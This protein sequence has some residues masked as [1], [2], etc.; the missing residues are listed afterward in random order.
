MVGQMMREQHQFDLIMLD[1]FDFNYIPRHLMTQE[2]LEEVKNILAPGGVLAANTFAGSDL[3]ERESATYA[4]VFG[5]YL[6]L[7]ANNRIIFAVNGA[8]P[9]ESQR[10]QNAARWRPALA[11]YGVNSDRKLALFGNMPSWPKTTKVL[12]D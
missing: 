12:K 10:A 9:D 1:A 11:P 6:N 8:L 7:A 3:Y 4:V 2:F 5:Q